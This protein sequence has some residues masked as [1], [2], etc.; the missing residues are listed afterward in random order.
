MTVRIFFVATLATLAAAC[1]KVESF[2][3]IHPASL[4]FKFESSCSC[5]NKGVFVVNNSDDSVAVSLRNF[6]RDSDGVFGERSFSTSLSPKEER[7]LGCERVGARNAP[8]GSSSCLADNWF[9]IQSTTQRLGYGSARIS[10]ASFSTNEPQGDLSHSSASNEQLPSCRTECLDPEAFTQNGLCS[11]ISLESTAESSGISNLARF[12]R[13]NDQGSID[14]RQMGSW[15]GVAS[16]SC[17]RSA[18]LIADGRLFN[19]GDACALNAEFSTF[20]ASQAVTLSI[21]SRLS[22]SR[23]HSGEWVSLMFDRSEE[24]P[25]LSFDNRMLQREFGGSIYKVETNARAV[26]FTTAQSCIWAE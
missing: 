20:G 10:F 13:E 11:K 19:S 2:G 22:A 4:S 18:T 16:D 14:Q 23:N 21:P 3:E 24:R 8:P 12:L 15:F 17:N 7:L 5:A 1:D 6:K 26:L 25:S 9:E